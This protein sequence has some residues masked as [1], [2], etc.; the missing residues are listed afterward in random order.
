MK[1]LIDKNLLRASA[2]F[3]LFCPRCKTLADARRWVLLDRDPALCLCAKCY[4]AGRSGRT[5]DRVLDG[6]KVFA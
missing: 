6:R 3:A 1:T 2:G 5:S 4:D